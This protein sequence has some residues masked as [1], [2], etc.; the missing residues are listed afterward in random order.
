MAW[1]VKLSDDAKRD[2]QKLDKPIQKRIAAF[3]Q[4]RIQAAENPRASGKALQGNLSGLWRY[5]VG[6]YRLL[7][8]F[9]DEELVVLVIE[10]GHRREIYR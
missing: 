6:D 9:E 8:R 4:E 2:L 3:L 10:I 7:C 5:R 1:T